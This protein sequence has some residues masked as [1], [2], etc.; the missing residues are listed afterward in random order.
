MP[1]GA[2]FQKE[3][4]DGLFGELNQ[5]YKGKPESEQ[6]HRDAHLAI[7]LFDAGRSL[8]KTIDDMLEDI[9]R[10]IHYPRE[11]EKERQFIVSTMMPNL[12]TSLLIDRSIQLAIEEKQRSAA[13]NTEI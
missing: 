6:L 10:G 9:D 13:S 3:H 7:A 4:I 5:D 11:R 1:S 2:M 8:P 12:P